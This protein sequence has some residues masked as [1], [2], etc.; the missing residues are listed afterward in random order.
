MGVKRPDNYELL[1]DETFDDLLFFANEIK[2]NID[3]NN[4][5]HI[6]FKDGAALEYPISINQLSSIVPES[7]DS[8]YIGEYVYRT[9]TINGAVVN[10]GSY[11]IEEGNL[12][13]FN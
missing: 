6:T 5:R 4:V 12:I 10:P 9:V 1:K 13:I 11:K 7:G 2:N 3:S 8:L